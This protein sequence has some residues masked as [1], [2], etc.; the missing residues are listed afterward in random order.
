MDYSKALR[1]ARAATGLQQREVASRSGLDPSHISLIEKGKR[2]PSI[3][4]VGRISQAL[5]IPDYLLTLLAAEPED[6]AGIEPTELA[7][8]AE[9]LT[10]FL[11]GH[12]KRG[13]RADKRRKRRI[14]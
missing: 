9:S 4:A 8:V 1:I 5:D 10:R 3:E 11:A 13:K 2:Q 14:A 12:G 7:R 6:I